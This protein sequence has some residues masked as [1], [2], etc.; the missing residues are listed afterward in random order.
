[1]RIYVA[2]GYEQFDFGNKYRRGRCIH[3]IV[4]VLLSSCLLLQTRRGTMIKNCESDQNSSHPIKF[5]KN[6]HIRLKF[7][8]KSIVNLMYIIVKTKYTLL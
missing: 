5:P 2:G 6:W 4:R 1:M 3:I 8:W 7:Q